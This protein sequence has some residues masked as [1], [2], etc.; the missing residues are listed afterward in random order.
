MAMSE[1]WK[2]A[3][4]AAIGG[5]CACS[6]VT[7]PHEVVSFSERVANEAAALIDELDAEALAERARA[8][9]TKGEAGR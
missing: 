1:D 4:F 5:C 2:R 7:D 3:F 8:T 9:A 6:N